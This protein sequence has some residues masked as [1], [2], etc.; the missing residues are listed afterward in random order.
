MS[1]PGMKARKQTAGAE[2]MSEVCKQIIFM[3]SLDRDVERFA[4]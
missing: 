2:N 4:R 1:T 3:K